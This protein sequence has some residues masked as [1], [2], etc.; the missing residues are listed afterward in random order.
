MIQIE[1][2]LPFPEES[3]LCCIC[4]IQLDKLDNRSLDVAAVNNNA[5]LTGA[6]PGF[7]LGGGALVSCSS[8]TAIN[9]IVF[10]F[11]IPVE[12]EKR[13]SSQGEGGGCAPPA[14]SPQIRPWLIPSE[15]RSRNF[16]QAFLPIFFS[17][18]CHF[19]YPHSLY[20]ESIV[21]FNQNGKEFAECRSEIFRLLSRL[22]SR[23]ALQ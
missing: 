15:K 10:L 23:R 19:I 17:C 7:F 3:P 21:I 2:I 22:K 1:T 4:H 12:L 8:S 5:Q 6:D 13:R 20:G 18:S 14:P 9:H 11:R 16:C